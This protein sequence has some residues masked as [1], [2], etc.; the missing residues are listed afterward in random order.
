MNTK[1]HFDNFND[2]PVCGNILKYNASINM[3]NC[4]SEHYCCG[5]EFGNSNHDTVVLEEYSLSNKLI[6]SRDFDISQVCISSNNKQDSSFIKKLNIEDD[7]YIVY[8]KYV[9]Y[10]ILK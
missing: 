3:L 1:N 2:C 7:L 6:I 8:N 5:L 9:K 10:M 4:D